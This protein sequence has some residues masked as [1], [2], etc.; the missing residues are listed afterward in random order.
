MYKDFVTIPPPNHQSTPL[1]AYEI[2]EDLAY[3]G[4]STPL[5]PAHFTIPFG[6]HKGQNLSEI[7]DQSYLRWLLKMSVDSKERHQEYCVSMRLKEL[8]S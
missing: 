8:S 4:H 5:T 7:T 1:V 2:D 3:T 6:K